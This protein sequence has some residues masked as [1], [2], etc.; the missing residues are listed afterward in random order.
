M[1]VI[2]RDGHGKDNDVDYDDGDGND[3]VY[4]GGDVNYQFL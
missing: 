1:M 4:N 3:H 2:K